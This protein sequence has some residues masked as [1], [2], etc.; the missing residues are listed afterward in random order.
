MACVAV[1]FVGCA[2]SAFAAVDVVGAVVLV[3]DLAAALALAVVVVG[4]VAVS[5]M[6]DSKQYVDDS[7]SSNQPWRQLA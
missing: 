7:Q 6:A 5:H 3:H 1:V 2:D 4:V